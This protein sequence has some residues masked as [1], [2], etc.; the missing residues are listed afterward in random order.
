VLVASPDQRMGELLRDVLDSMGLRP[1][2]AGNGGNGER[3]RG[4]GLLVLDWG[5]PEQALES[6]LAGRAAT[7]VLLLCGY[8]GRPPGLPEDRVTVLQKPFALADLRAAVGR[9]MGLD[10]PC[11]PQ[12]HSG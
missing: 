10:E 9:A 6:L 11:P 12:R 4:C 1:R 7:P 3:D 8:E 5:R 2:L